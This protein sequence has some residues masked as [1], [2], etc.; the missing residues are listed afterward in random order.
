V[1]AYL[2]VDVRRFKA[3]FLSAAPHRYRKDAKALWDAFGYSLSK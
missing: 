3:A 2:L 1:G